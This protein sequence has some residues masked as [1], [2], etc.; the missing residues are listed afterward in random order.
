MKKL[1]MIIGMVGLTLAFGTA[2]A[3]DKDWVLS[4]GITVFQS[5]PEHASV[6]GPEMALDNGITIFDTG[7]ASAKADEHSASGSA[8]GGM[9]SEEKPVELY[10]GVTV[11]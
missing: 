9:G 2:F 4:N 1:L 3:A 6:A 11:F 8:A 5:S 10:N 7:I